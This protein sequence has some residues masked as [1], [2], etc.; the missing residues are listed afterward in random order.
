MRRLQ[1]RARFLGASIDLRGF[2]GDKPKIS[3]PLSLPEGARGHIIV[4]R[5]GAVVCFDL[6]EAEQAAL[7]QRLLRF[8]AGA[9]P[10]PESES[11]DIVVDPDRTERVDG[12]TGELVLHDADADRLE[13]VAHI[14][15]KSA[16]LAHYESRI[17]DAFGRIEGLADQLKGI[18]R[19]KRS[20]DLMRDIGEA[21][22]I[23]AR[24]VG[25]V[26]VTEKPEITWETPELDRLYSR[27]ALEYELHDRDLALTRK[28]TLISDAAETYLNL[29]H[30]RQGLRLE[31]YIVALIVLEVGLSL[32]ELFL[33]H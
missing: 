32:Y 26:E 29:L 27:L 8:V 31:W 16:V 15:A 20:R 11:I 12:D 5:F 2:A 25:R 33:R 13:V 17:A 1:A 18:A 7:D 3:P 24:T 14:L 9:F 28:V 4:F 6:D 21:L 23:Q 30:S 22:A 10:A 19:P